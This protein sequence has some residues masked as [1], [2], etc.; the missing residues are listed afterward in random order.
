MSSNYMRSVHLKDISG[1]DALS[2]QKRIYDPA[3][4][5]PQV[6]HWHD[7]YEMEFFRTGSGT[8]FL[9]GRQTDFS[10]GYM[11]LVTPSDFH[12]L[13][14]DC[15]DMQYYN[16][17]FS[18]LAMPRRVRDFITSR[19]APAE[20]TLSR[21]EADQVVCELEK[22]IGE[23]DSNDR[24]STDMKLECFGKVLIIFCRA[25]IRQNEDSLENPGLYNSAVRRAM[26]IV[27]RDFGQNIG[28]ASIA[29]EIGYSPNY[30]GS[31]FT[32]EI[33]MSFTE[34]LQNKRISYAE[35]LLN[36]SDLPVKEISEISG[37]ASPSYFI[38]VFKKKRGCTPASLRHSKK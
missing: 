3:W 27:Q 11:F 30:L 16:I 5:H 20:V 31:L 15:S 4:A 38:S 13:E 34:Y 22:I 6:Y 24:F 28:I 35:N 17:N 29:T 26:D 1:R 10:A 18:E 33:G 2:V 37:F 19:N 21:E 25:I 12:R 7:Y 9:S 36:T 8:H 32:A 14:S 23:S